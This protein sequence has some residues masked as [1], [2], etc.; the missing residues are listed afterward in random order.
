M[1]IIEGKSVHMRNIVFLSF[2]QTNDIIVNYLRA[3]LCCSILMTFGS[4]VFFIKE[5]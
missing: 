2:C 4:I 5:S 1:K 3:D